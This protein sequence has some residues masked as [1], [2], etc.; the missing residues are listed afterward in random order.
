MA[1]GKDTK[2][3]LSN[4]L[5]VVDFNRADGQYWLSDIEGF[6]SVETAIYDKQY[7][8]TPGAS[9]TGY[10]IAA[11][12]GTL[13]GVIF[14]ETNTTR[15]HLLHVCAPGVLTRLEVIEPDLTT[16]LEVYFEKTP[17]IA[18]GMG[19][20]PFIA[21]IYAEFPYWRSERDNGG[22]VDLLGVEPEFQFPKNFSDPAP[23]RFGYAKKSG[24]ANV[25]L[26]GNMPSP[27]ILTVTNTGAAAINS[28][29]I[30]N[31]VDGSTIKTWGNSF[32]LTT[33]DYLTID[34]YQKRATVTTV[35]DSGAVLVVNAFPFLDPA[36][37]IS[38]VM[39][40]GDNFLEVDIQDITG[41]GN[42]VDAT[43]LLTIPGGVYSGI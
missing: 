21:E 10:A 17:E 18:P 42:D 34:T 25:H 32:S 8:G 14:E 19:V 3:R 6:S 35:Y 31:P 26:D 33:N 24:G 22:S 2:F 1:M 29:A 36:S 4:D 5:G 11:R 15:R 28:V 43:A 38:M 27:F 12:R 30:T 41:T 39:Y 13:D 40:P 37:N 9:L 20:Q 7:L 16:Y 23:W